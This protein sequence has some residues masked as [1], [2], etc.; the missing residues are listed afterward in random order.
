MKT[1]KG[2]QCVDLSSGNGTSIT[3][4]Q[5]KTQML[6]PGAKI[7]IG[8]TTILFEDAPRASVSSK[9][10]AAKLPVIAAS[11]SGKPPELKPS[12]AKAAA[13]KI[14]TARVQVAPTKRTTE[15]VEAV[16]PASQ[17]GLRPATHAVPKSGSRMGRTT[18]R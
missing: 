5:I 7:T 8:S 15:R 13:S 3:G 4:T 2:Y 17:A 12:P 10:A 18:G 1:P 9:A 16:R 6:S 14:A 11:S